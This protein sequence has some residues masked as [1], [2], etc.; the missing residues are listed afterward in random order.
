MQLSCTT[1]SYDILWYLSTDWC[2]IS[3]N[4]C[5]HFS[6]PRNNIHATSCKNGLSKPPPLYVSPTHDSLSWTVLNQII[7]PKM[8]IYYD[9]TIFCCFH[10]YV[11]IVWHSFT[12]CIWARLLFSSLTRF[13]SDRIWSPTAATSGAGRAGRPVAP[14]ASRMLGGCFRAMSTCVVC[15][16][17]VPTHIDLYYQS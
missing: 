3:A 1:Q 2:R 15:Y 9:V 12:F 6:V 4:M 11:G 8:S 5:A 16:H 17:V 10:Y 7:I 13:P 14:L